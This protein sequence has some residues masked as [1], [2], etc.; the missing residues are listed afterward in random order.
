MGKERVHDS[1]CRHCGHLFMDLSRFSLGSHFCFLDYQYDALH[2][3]PVDY[4]FCDSGNYKEC[5]KFLHNE[6]IQKKLE[7]EREEIINSG[8]FTD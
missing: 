4:A 5:G 3:T 1:N 8:I 2:G 6:S 7:I